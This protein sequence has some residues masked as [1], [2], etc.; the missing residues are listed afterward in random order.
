MLRKIAS[1]RI[2]FEVLKE[3]YDKKRKDGLVQFL[4]EP[5]INNKPRITKDK[6]VL[7]KLI[8]FFESKQKE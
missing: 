8:T 7:N 4:K 2:T 1:Q 5:L 6:R 3:E